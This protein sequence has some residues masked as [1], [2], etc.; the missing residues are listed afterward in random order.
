MD[1]EKSEIVEK[2]YERSET[3]EMNVISRVIT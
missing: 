3:T 2:D 1:F